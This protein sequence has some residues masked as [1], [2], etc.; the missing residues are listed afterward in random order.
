MFETDVCACLEEFDAMKKVRISYNSS[1]YSDLDA[2]KERIWSM[3]HI[4]S[5]KLT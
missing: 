1:E 4:H 3:S 5:E 2:K